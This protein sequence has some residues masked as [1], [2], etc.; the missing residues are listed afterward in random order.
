M[1][2]ILLDKNIQINLCFVAKEKL[3]CRWAELARFLKVSPSTLA[4]WY[5]YNHLLPQNIFNKL[6]QISSI[7][8]DNM[9]VLS[10]NWGRS[11]GGQRTIQRYGKILCGFKERVTGKAKV[12]AANKKGQRA[13]LR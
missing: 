13:F 8:I 4:N 5:K 1:S 12:I 10:D 7:S 6:I 3:N 2:R 11:L 9:E